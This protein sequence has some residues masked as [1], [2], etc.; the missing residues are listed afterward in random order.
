MTKPSLEGRN[1]AYYFRH[2]AQILNK[3][4]RLT[5]TVFIGAGT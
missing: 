3:G 1:S 5:V 2:F 4:L